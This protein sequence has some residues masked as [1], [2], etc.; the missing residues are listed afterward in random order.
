MGKSF[1]RI[2]GKVFL[3]IAG[4]ALGLMILLEVILSGAVLTRIVDGIASEYVDGDIHFG[5]V[6][7]SLFRRFP[8]TTLTL[9]DFHITYPADRFDLAEKAGVQGHLM[10]RGCGQEADTLA[11]FRRFSVGIN[12]FSLIRGTVDVPYMR[13]DHPRIFAHSYADGSAN[14]NIFKTGNASDRTEDSISAEAS[15]SAAAEA[16]EGSISKIAIGRIMMTGRPHI[17]YTDSRDTV[18]AMINLKRLMLAGKIKSDN[19]RRS[20]IGLT[21]DSMFVAGRLGR[22]TIA[23]GIDRLYLHEEGRAVKVEAAAK[24]FLATASMGRIK[25]PLSIDGT[26]AFP[27]DSVLAVHTDDL[28]VKVLNIPVHMKADARLGEAI[29]FDARASIP[30]TGL[31]HPDFPGQELTLKMDIGARTDSRGRINVDIDD[32]R[33]GIKGVGLSVKG[34]VRDALGEDPLIEVNGNLSAALDTVVRFLPDTLGIE[35]AGVVKASVL[36]QARLSQLDIYNFS[37]SSLTGE[38][39]GDSITVRMPADTINATVEGLRIFLGPEDRTSRRDSTKTVK[40]MGIS[41]EIASADISYKDAL[42]LKASDF[43]ISAKNVMSADTT[44]KTHPFSGRVSAGKLM[45]RDSEGAVIRLNESSNSFNIFPKKGQPKVPVLTLT[46]RNKGVF[47]KADAGRVVMSNANIRAKAAMNTVERRKKMREFRDSL[48]KAYPDIPRDSLFRHMMAQKGPRAELPEWMKE[49]D[50]RS[51]DIDI[52]LDKSIAKYFRDWDLDGRFSI[53]KGI[54]M[55]PYFPLRNTLQGFDLTFSNDRIGIEKFAAKSGDSDISATGELTGLRRALLGRRGMLK[56]DADIVSNGMNANQLLAAYSTGSNYKPVADEAAGDEEVSDEEYM[57]QIILDTAAVVAAPS[58]IVVPANLNAEISLKASDI[59]YSD[60][61]IS[62]ATAGLLMKERCIQIRET[63]ALTNMG[64]ISMEGF[65]ATQSK[66]DIKAGFSLNFKDIT[67]EK[68][69]NLMPAID[70]LMPLLKSFG[71]L[72]NCEVAATTRLDTAMNIIMPSINGILRIGGDNLTIKDNEMFRK[73]ARLLVFKNTKEGRIDKMTV[74]GV[75]KDSKVEVFPFIL[76]MDR[77][78]LGL[79]GVQNM[80]MSFRY[81][82]SLIKSPFLVKLGMDIY[83]PDFDNMKFKIGKPKYKSRNV[84]VFSAVIDDT[85]VNLVESMRNVFDK[86]VDAVMKESAA[87]KAIEDHKKSIGYVQAVDQK[88]EELSA[89]EQ[90]QLETEQQGEYVSTSLDMTV[91][92]DDTTEKK[93]DMTEAK[94]DMTEK[95]GNSK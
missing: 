81:H 15:D 83:G 57:E 58:L 31:K 7:A 37:K 26:V 20:R 82:A 56:L 10:Y 41:G 80:D 33:A 28:K 66:K 6:R 32:F 63:K 22:D 40:L 50:F 76:E 55:T 52:S 36:G 71:G 44:V 25:V 8:A 90:K 68:V 59:A 30:R 84:P 91:K 79:S 53:E 86:G 12:P 61:L 49:E 60:L 2:S 16:G 70:T 88:M 14:W 46:S 4:T 5:K 69:I 38:M 93:A 43:R 19:V 54:L 78:M 62:T 42:M 35:A 3:C 74:E 24:A 21:M 92:E 48:A 64:D 11:S 67:A 27:K 13:L 17:V 85:K 73:M 65:Y 95:E 1:F 29:S 47:V 34:K 87:Q 45:L 51:Q 89:D 18:F 23:A 9:E 77:Y 94:T 39:T 75:I 72:L